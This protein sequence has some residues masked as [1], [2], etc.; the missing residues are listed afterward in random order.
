MTDRLPRSARRRIAL[1]GLACGLLWLCPMPTAAAAMSREAFIREADRVCRQQDKKLAA[2]PAPPH[3]SPLLQHVAYEHWATLMH[4]TFAGYDTALKAIAAP[5][6]AGPFLASW[7]R[8]KKSSDAYITTYV[9]YGALAG[10]TPQGSA[11][12]KANK[13]FASAS[14]AYGL[15]V[16]GRRYASGKWPH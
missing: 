9:K 4:A 12:V 7:R 14:A 16:C 1:S 15:H 11:S 3:G 6:S 13:G 8:L 10:F 2:T 5:P